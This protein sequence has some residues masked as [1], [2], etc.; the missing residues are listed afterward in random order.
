VTDVTATRRA[1]R[2]LLLSILVIVVAPLVVLG[3]LLLGLYAL[4]VICTLLS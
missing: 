2:T 3:T 4:Q 1:V